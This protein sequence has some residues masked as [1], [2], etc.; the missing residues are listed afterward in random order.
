MAN[1]SPDWLYIMIVWSGP[2]YHQLAVYQDS[3]VRASISP[4]WLYIR[5][6]WSWPIYHNWL[7]IMIV[8]SGPVYHQT[9]CI[10]GQSGQGQYITILAVYQDILVR[11]SISPDWLYIM[12][13]WS[14]PV[15]H[16]TGCIS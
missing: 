12:I 2:V 9:G 8:W 14:G 5:T 13:I 4:D 3:L 7:D 16:Q 10:S 15:Y 6:V 1:I 11:A